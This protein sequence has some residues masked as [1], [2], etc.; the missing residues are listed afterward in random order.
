MLVQDNC[1]EH[2]CPGL[3]A[4]HMYTSTLQTRTW[5]SI[6]VLQILQEFWITSM[7]K[8][9]LNLFWCFFQGENFRVYEISRNISK[10]LRMS[11]ADIN[12]SIA[13]AVLQPLS[14]INIYIFCLFSETLSLVIKTANLTTANL[15]NI[16]PYH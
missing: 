7:P 2:H 1:N 3:S 16:T 15:H 11:N 10:I 12:S 4:P 6:H 5:F 9:Y 8:N 14:T 13:T